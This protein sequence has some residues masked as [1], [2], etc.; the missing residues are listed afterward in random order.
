MI[1]YSLPDSTPLTH[2]Q[3]YTSGLA[4]LLFFNMKF[5]GHTRVTSCKKSLHCLKKWLQNVTF[6]V[7]V[8]SLAL[9]RTVLWR[10][11]L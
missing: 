8:W 11:T 5:V 7:T 9:V 2:T 10:T 3:A 6:L 1:Y 4:P